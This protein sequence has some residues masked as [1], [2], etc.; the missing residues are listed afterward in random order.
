M[1]ETSQERIKWLKKGMITPVMEQ[2]FIESNGIKFVRGNV[3]PNF[4]L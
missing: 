1:F 2:L 4:L 3:C